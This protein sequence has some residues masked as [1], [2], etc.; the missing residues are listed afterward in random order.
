MFIKSRH[1]EASLA[2]GKSRPKRGSG[3]DWSVAELI[4][5]RIL[6]PAQGGK[7]SEEG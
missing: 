1:R 6:A 3:D 7:E 2:C 5:L 4:A